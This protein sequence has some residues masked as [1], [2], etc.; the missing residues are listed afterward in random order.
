MIEMELKQAREL[1]QEYAGQHTVF[2]TA[3]NVAKRYYEKKNDILYGKKADDTDSEN[4]LRN[5]DNRVPSNFYRLQVNQKAAYAFTKPPKFDVGDEK[6]NDIIAT[7]LGDAYKKKCKALCIQAANNAVAWL[8][9]WKNENGEFRYAVVDST[10]IIPVWSE[11]LEKELYA[12]LRTYT[13]I[14]RENGKKYIIY[15][16]WTDTECQAFQREENLPLDQLQYCNMYAA[17]EMS[18]GEAE[19]SSIYRHDWG[20]VPFIFFN[21]NDEML[22]DLT[23]VKELIDSYDK[24]YSGFINDLQD[25]QELIF[26]L[27]NYGG[28]AEDAASVL[29]EMRTKK[30]I[31][32]ESEGADD[33]SGI[34]TLA[35]DIPVEAREKVLTMTRKA[36]FEQGMAIDPD[37]QNF[38]NS[39]GVALSYLYSLLEL[40]TG[41]LETEFTISFNH[42]VRAILK[43]YGMVPKKIEQTWTRTSVSNDAELADIASKSKGVISDETIV[44]NH[45]WVKDP[46][47]EL[48][49]LEKQKASEE[50]AWD[51]VPPAKEDVIDGEEE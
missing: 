45:P 7:S 24:V 30:V 26:I 33:R 40:K 2:V 8:H 20:V 42:L 9:Y 41:M 31:Q 22:S 15:E 35:I 46:K 39:S 44:R 14:G 16:I 29:E 36:I 21:N 23:D 17:V 32:V 1:I 50:P 12:V 10:Q 19:Y 49:L 38:G 25:I 11:D 27:T 4:P 34:S 43:C 3:A 51:Q 18:T 48:E 28:E 37:P 47:D 6:A 5:S 13:K